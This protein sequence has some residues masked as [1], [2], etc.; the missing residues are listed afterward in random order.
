M[1]RSRAEAH[2]TLLVIIGVIVALVIVAVVVILSRGAP[3]KLDSSTPEGV[4]QRYSTA[5]IDGDENAAKQFLVADLAE[6]CLRIQPTPDRTMRVTLVDAVERA[7]SA[8]VRVL[9]VTTSGG[10]IFGPDEYRED[11]TFDLVR[12]GGEWRIE[13]TPWQLTICERRVVEP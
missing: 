10:G 13:T 9:I 12:E 3:V 8:D 2:R 1:E 4:V 11:G 6:D 5:V 7:A